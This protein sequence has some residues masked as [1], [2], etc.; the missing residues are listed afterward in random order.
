MEALRPVKVSAA[1]SRKMREFRGQ[2]S[3]L[4]LTKNGSRNVHPTIKALESRGLVK[5]QP[6]S[7]IAHRVKIAVLTEQGKAWMRMIERATETAV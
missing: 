3:L 7:T 4:A 1:M 2:D 6:V 5:V